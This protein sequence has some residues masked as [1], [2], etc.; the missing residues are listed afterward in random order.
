MCG[1]VVVIVLSRSLV[2]LERKIT[3]NKETHQGPYHDRIKVVGEGSWG[4]ITVLSPV[5]P[6]IG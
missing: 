4:F 1:K 5:S 3:E 2:H 6:F